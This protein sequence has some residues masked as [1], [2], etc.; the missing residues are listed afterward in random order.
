VEI[1]EIA[2]IAVG[3]VALVIFILSSSFV[4]DQAEKWVAANPKDPAAAKVLFRA[5]RWCDL[6][7]DNDRAVITYWKLYEQYPGE[8]KLVAEALYQCA[9]IKSEGQN[10]LVLRQQANQYLRIILDQYG[11]EAEWHA[12]AQK[13]FDEVNYVH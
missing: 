13:L 5:A 11:V 3:L 7:G 2:G 6:M 1:K 12:K 9:V 8:T 4:A 10:I